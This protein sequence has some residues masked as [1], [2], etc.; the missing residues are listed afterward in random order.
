M[1]D[2]NF[3]PDGFH[4]LTPYIIVHD[5]PAAIDFYQRAFGAVELSRHADDKGRIRHA[6]LRFGDS[7]MMLAEEPGGEWPDWQSARTRG[8][9]PV[10]L[11][12]YVE[13]P[14]AVFATA[15]DAGATQLLPMED[16]DYGDRS[17]GL[18]DPFGHVWYVS[19]VLGTDAAGESTHQQAGS[20]SL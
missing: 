18:T 9:T 15:I 4:T 5:G 8:G 19:K 10:H 7:P 20:A 2:R 6:E 16:H 13:D 17:G 1:T 3:R 12:M 14:D 11:Y